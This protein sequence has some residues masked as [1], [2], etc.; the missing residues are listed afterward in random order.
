MNAPT[1]ST[2]MDLASLLSANLDDIADLPSF[3]VPAAGF[4]KLGLSITV[5]KINDKDAVEFS[6]DVR[7]T[8]ELAEAGATPPVAGTKF[9][10]AFQISNAIG[11]GKFKEAAK[12]LMAALGTSSYADIL[13][14]QVVGMEVFATLKRRVDK[15]DPDKVY[16]DVKNITVA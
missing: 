15:T 12:P 14:G 9:S 3:E 6:F 5:K 13:G 8:L 11:L 1:Q 10:V 4:Y 2:G 7:E 16:A